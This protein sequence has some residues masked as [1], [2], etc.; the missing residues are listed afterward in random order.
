MHRLLQMDRVFRDLDIPLQPVQYREL[1][2]RIQKNELT[3]SFSIWQGYLL[4]DYDKYNLMIKHHRHFTCLEKQFARKKN[5]RHC[6]DLQGT[7]E[8]DR[9]DQTSNLLAA[10]SPV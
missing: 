9:S 10:I 6:L 1:E 2:K 3:V 8:T 4:M 5:R 7:A